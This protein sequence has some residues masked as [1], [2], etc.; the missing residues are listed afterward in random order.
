MRQWPSISIGVTDEAEQLLLHGLEI[1]NDNAG[2]RGN[3]FGL[4]LKQGRLEKAESLLKE[5]YGDSVDGLPEQLQQYYYIQK[6]LN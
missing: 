6:I 4:L 2:M 3:Y 1:A 5:Q